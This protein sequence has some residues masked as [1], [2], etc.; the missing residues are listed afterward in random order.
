MK[1]KWVC[2]VMIFA[3][4]LLFPY[5]IFAVDYS[6]SNVDINAYLQDNGLVEVEE[7]FTYEFDGEFNGIIREIVP[8]EGTAITQFSASEG[9]KTLVVD[10]EDHLFRVHR[11]G[12]DEI[13][14]VTLHYTI[15]NG[16]EIY[17][18]IAQ[19]YWPFFDK[20]NQSTYEKLSIT[21]H[22][23]E[24]TSDVIAFGY[25]EAFNKEMIQPDG[26][27]RFDYGTVPSSSNG[28]IRVAYDQ[29][30]F[31]TSS[32][33]I[34]KLM[35]DEVLNAQEELIMKAESRVAK[36]DSLI[37]IANIGIPVFTII[38]LLLFIKDWIKVRNKRLAIQREGSIFK[39]LPKQ[40]LSLP[41]TIYFT[42]HKQLPP[43]AMA[44]GLLDLVRQGYVKKVSDH[45]FKLIE[46]NTNLLHEKL[47]ITWLFEKMG[48][49]GEFCFSDLK[50]YTKKK[51]NH[52]KYSMF[53]TSWMHAVRK[54]VNEYS[55]YENKSKYRIAIGVSSLILLPFIILFP[56]F[57]LFG[58]L[59]A[60]VILFFTTIIYAI[61]YM[62]KTYEGLRI[63]NE[64]KE[65]RNR[66][67]VITQSDWEQWSEDERMRAYIYGLGINQKS[68]VKK[69]E[70][71]T[72]A[73]TPPHRTVDHNQTA[74]MSSFVYIGPM[75]SSNFH[76]ASQS[77][78]STTSSGSSSSSSGTGGGGGGSGAF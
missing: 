39:S 38:L 22:P 35:K 71:L 34:N 69:N 54:E 63:A 37:T 72:K 55:L 46:R 28:D 6:I 61:A 18:D 78:A 20:R 17:Q 40:M 48:G 15:E 9:G 14:M 30:L 41:A 16:V 26:S 57:G 21:V 77:A 59:L 29:S 12:K 42:N 13:I 25:D 31:L 4:F 60:T 24:P 2:T 66:F 45:C 10:H 19:F 58:P 47:L 53:Q 27:V 50:S 5:P 8:K 3:L 33:P 36:R 68:L 65:F 56:I 64:W 75:A 73:F 43:Q 49:N 51:K 7:T 23:P 44:A 52:D 70:E 11:Q 74:D 32:Q 67:N 1:K 76:S 62:P